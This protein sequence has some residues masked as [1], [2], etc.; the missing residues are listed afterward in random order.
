MNGKMGDLEIQQCIES[1][2]DLMNT[3]RGE[4]DEGAIA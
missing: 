2:H 3:S 4:T 1:V